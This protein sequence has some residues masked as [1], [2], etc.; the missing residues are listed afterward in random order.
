MLKFN[1]S[2]YEVSKLFF[3]FSQL[4]CRLYRRG[5]YNVACCNNCIFGI[6]GITQKISQKFSLQM[7]N[8]SCICL[9]SVNETHPVRGEQNSRNTVYR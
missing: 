9:L 2:L 1:T 3:F 7:E 8:T 5:C 6:F 4:F